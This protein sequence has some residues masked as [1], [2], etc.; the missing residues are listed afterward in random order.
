[1]RVFLSAFDGFKIA[2][3]MR[4]VSSIALCTDEEYCR[5]KGNT[6]ISLPHLFNLP[7][8]TRYC[9]TLKNADDDNAAEKGVTIL[10]A[11]IE[12]ETEIPAEEIY[13]LPELLS[14]MRFSGLFNGILLN[15]FPFLLL[16]PQYLAESEFYITNTIKESEA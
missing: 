7:Q 10:T 9:V 11:E 3:P 1:M 16:N 2:I 8:E 6:C 13:P 14:V 4:S 12:Y 15:P 5:A